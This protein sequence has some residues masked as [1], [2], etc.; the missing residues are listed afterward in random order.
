MDIRTETSF[1]PKRPI[2]DNQGT[3]PKIN[4]FFISA[5][6]L[7]VLSLSLA[8]GVWLRQG[9]LVKQ[10]EKDKA[11]LLEARKEYSEDS[12]NDLIRL[13]DRLSV[14]AN[15]L[16]NHLSLTPIFSILEKNI[17]RRVRVNSLSISYDLD[18]KMKIDLSGIAVNYD[19]LL[20]QS[21]SFSQGEL[22]NIITG[23]NI[24]DIGP[25]EVGGVSFRLTAFVNKDIL[26]YKNTLTNAN[27]SS[28]KSDLMISIQ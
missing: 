17:L 23:F 4:L 22:A 26:S 9:Y 14:S 20:K 6:I 25:A 10:L 19:V 27:N 8:F 1:I 5:I 12:I 3:H 13:D 2:I 7:F 16:N 18:N 21:E 28:F 11:D 24:S 15:L